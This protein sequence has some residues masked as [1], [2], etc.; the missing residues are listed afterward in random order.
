MGTPRMTPAEQEQ[1]ERATRRDWEAIVFMD[2][3]ETH[4]VSRESMAHKHFTLLD[5]LYKEDTT[6]EG[7]AQ[8]I[9]DEFA[10]R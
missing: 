4:N 2:L 1:M 9:A 10:A 8:I 6:P 5:S 3:S 7:A